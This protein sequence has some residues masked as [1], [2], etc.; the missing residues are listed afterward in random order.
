MRLL[1]LAFILAF[2]SSAE[3][4]SLPR[5]SIKDK[6][7]DKLADNVVEFFDA[8]EA[9][10]IIDQRKAL[11]ELEAS[12]AKMA[13]SARLD[14]SPLKYLGDWEQVFEKAKVEDRKIKAGKGF[15]ALTFEDR[16]D[17]T[18]VTY[19]MSIPAGYSKRGA[20]LYPAI[21]A[22]KPPLEK[23]GSELEEAVQAMAEATYGDLMDK[24]IILVPLGRKQG[25]GRKAATT[26]V[27]SSWMTDEGLYTLFTSFRTLLENV[28]FDRSRLVVDGWGDAGIDAFRLASRA[29][30]WFAGAINRSGD[31]GT[32]DD[33]IFQN[34]RDVPLLYV[35]GASDG[36]EADMSALEAAEG[37]ALETVAEEGSAMAPGDEARGKIAEWF[38]GRQHSLCPTDIDYRL[39]NI[40]YQS[41]HWVKAANIN[42]RPTAKPSDEDFPR[43]KAEV[44]QGS[45]TIK[46]ETTNVLGGVYV[47]LSDAL[48]DMDKPVA[49]EVNGTER[50]KRHFE[51]DIQILLENRF[52]NN[53]G[54]CGLYTNMV[55]IEEID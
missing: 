46:I 28:R 12:L 4:S 33:V 23:G 53:S 15:T 25:E 18:P 54:D 44:D 5:S 37:L 14:D 6:D 55:L 38:E 39:D 26:E 48:V 29:P 30:F 43:I 41:M 8:L 27:E 9:D 51:R 42:K 45:N 52:F 49:I 1:I 22:L 13:K 17:S 31:V 36:R 32:A 19:L 20:G 24:A 50:V 21:L 3:D 35:N 11:D 16:W 47:F 10:K 34:L 40:Q 2:C 7:L